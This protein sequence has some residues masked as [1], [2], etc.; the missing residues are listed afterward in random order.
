[1]INYGRITGRMGSADPVY[2]VMI[3]DVE[4]DRI[5]RMTAVRP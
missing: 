4:G 5:V 1:L 3:Y 2:L